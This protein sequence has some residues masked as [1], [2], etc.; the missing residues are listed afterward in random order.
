MLIL[1]N[2]LSERE[3]YEIKFKK[4]MKLAEMKD[5]KIMIWT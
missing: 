5:I 3:I 2:K 1:I 4:A